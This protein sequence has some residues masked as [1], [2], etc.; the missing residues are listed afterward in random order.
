MLDR[1]Y[2]DR[3]DRSILVF[4]RWL[5]GSID[6]YPIE[7]YLDRSAKIAFDRLVGF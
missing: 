1:I 7:H 2:L 6:L 5:F 3:S 4:D